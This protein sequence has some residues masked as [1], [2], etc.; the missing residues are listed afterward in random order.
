[1]SIHT[2]VR[3]IADNDGDLA[4]IAPRAGWSA[5]RVEKARRR[6]TI[7]PGTANTLDQTSMKM[8]AL[9]HDGSVDGQGNVAAC[10]S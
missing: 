6:P 8:V 7:R 9:C 10:A 3:L 4:S 2:D 5:F 1:M